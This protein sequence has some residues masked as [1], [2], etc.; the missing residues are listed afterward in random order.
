MKF[1]IN[2]NISKK[3]KKIEVAAIALI[4]LLFVLF[5][6]R[7]LITATDMFSHDSICWYGA[8][9]FF[10]DALSG[11]IFPYWDPYNACGQPFYYNLGILRLQEPITIAFI[12]LAK[13]LHISILTI[14]HWDYMIRILLT[15]IG[16]YLCYRQTNKYVLSNLLVF[17][18]F[19][20]SSFTTTSL[21]QNGVLYILFWIPWVT[22]FILRLLKN[23]SLYN[24]IGFSF[25]TGLTLCNYQGVYLLTYLFIFFLTLFINHRAYIFSQLKDSR[26]LFFIAIGIVIIII[27]ALPLL[28]VYIEQNKIV[29]ITRL[30]S[31]SAITKGIAVEYASLVEG[32]SHSSPADFSELAFPLAAKGYFFKWDISESFLYIGL[33]PFMLCFFGLFFSRGKYNIN[34]I[35]TLITIGLLMVGPK[36]AIHPL[37]YFLFY[38]FRFARHMHLFAGLFIFV[39]VYFLGQGTDF[40]IDNFQ[41]KDNKL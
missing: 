25:F 32:G 5:F 4:S 18:V 23:F 13:I 22:Y 3:T 28:S 35:I 2:L 26:K 1:N 7:I 11:G 36:G 12:F 37:V 20:F 17:A 15:G 38:P 34:F 19:I 27:L 29:P 24:I 14:Y 39:L 9:H 8:Y 30:Q 41:K 10:A 6:H 40:M 21:R 31:K 16:T 33:I